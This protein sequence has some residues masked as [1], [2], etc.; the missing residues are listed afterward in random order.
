MAL[1]YETSDLIRLGVYSA[2]EGNF[3]KSGN[4]NNYRF[5]FH[6]NQIADIKDLLSRVIGYEVT[7]RVV[8]SVSSEELYIELKKLGFEKF[9]ADDWNVPILSAWGQHGKNE[10]IRALID[11]L[12][13][14]DISEEAPYIQLQS[15]NVNSIKMI[16]NIFGGNI[17]GPYG[18]SPS[19]YLRWSGKN[20]LDLLDRL[21][22][23][24]YNLRNQ[25][26][27]ELIRV[28]RWSDYLL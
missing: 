16:R 10:Y 8:A 18:R 15:V 4:R 21:D 5:R 26:G 9:R 19:V 25:R 13:N 24:F 27:A 12:G 2:V 17:T 20:A 7:G 6:L 28:I 3:I 11:S 14:V 22:W 1:R 23:R